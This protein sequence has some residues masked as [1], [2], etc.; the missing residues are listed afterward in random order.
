MGVAQPRV[1]TTSGMHRLVTV[2][3]VV[4]TPTNPSP[5][6]VSYVCV[7][8]LTRTLFGEVTASGV[9]SVVSFIERHWPAVYT[10][11]WPKRRNYRTY[12]AG[13]SK[14]V[15]KCIKACSLPAFFATS[16]D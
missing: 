5:L 12:G 7:F 10:L 13:A 1:Q 15:V 3:S 6:S 14:L 4:V 11:E 8:K 9:F 16:S 2:S